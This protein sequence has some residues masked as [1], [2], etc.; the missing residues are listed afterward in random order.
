MAAKIIDGKTIAQQVRS[1]VAARVQQRLAQGKRAPGLAVVLV[2]ENPASQI[3][4]ASKRRS[5]EEVGFISRSYDLPA[6]TSEGELLKL[7][8]DLNNDGEIDGI[9]VQ[10]PLPAGIDNIK[11]LERIHPDKDVDGFHPYNVGRL[12]QRAPTLRPCTPR[13]IVTLLERYGIDT[14]GLNAVV[15]GASNIVGRPMSMELLLAGCTTT[16]THRFTK[17]LRH[18]VENADLVVVAVGKPGFIPGEWIK[19]G[20]IVIDVGI[21]RLESG[22]VVGDVEYDAAAERASFITPVPGGV[23]PMTVATL[24]Q[25]TLQACEEY[26]DISAIKS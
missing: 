21:N 23:G 12:C 9:L 25:N 7:I 11:V 3:Y 13:G 24:I 17:N 26:H 2:G 6:T 4:V 16:V 10:L 20:A 14:F 19:P 1:E 15:I 8:D 22:K 5:C 18:H